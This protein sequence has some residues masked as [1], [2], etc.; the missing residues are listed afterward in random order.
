MNKTSKF[1]AN[2]NFV[3]VCTSFVGKYEESNRN[4]AM[5]DS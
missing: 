3:L 4:L 2:I 1:S 5:I